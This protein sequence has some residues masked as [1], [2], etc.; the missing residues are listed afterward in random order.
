MRCHV[1]YSNTTGSIDCQF[2]ATPQFLSARLVE[3]DNKHWCHFHCPVK[4]DSGKG[5]DKS[6]WQAYNVR[7]LQSD[8]ASFIR[9]SA[10][11]GL[12]VNLSYVVF[13]DG[14]NM[15]GMAELFSNQGCSFIFDYSKFYCKIDLKKKELTNTNFNCAT[16][17]NFVSFIECSLTYSS[18]FN[19]TFDGGSSFVFCNFLAC[20]FD[21]VIFYKDA[22]FTEAMFANSIARDEE[23][24]F[25]DVV[26]HGKAIFVN[27]VFCAG[28]SLRNIKFHDLAD[29]SAQSHRI[30]DNRNLE[31]GVFHTISFNG[32]SFQEVDFTNRKFKS[33]TDFT[34]CVFNKAPNFHGCIFHQHTIFPSQNNFKDVSTDGAASAY[35]VIY[36]AM[37]DLKDRG[38]ES[39][40]YALVQRSERKSG[41]QPYHVRVAS[42]LYEVTT[43]Y[44]Q[45]IGRP[46]VVLLLVTI[47]FSCLYA[48]LASPVIDVY[49]SIDWGIVGNSIDLSVFQIVKPFAFYSDKSTKMVQIL[50]RGHP[51]TFKLTAI[52][53]TIFSLSLVTLFLLSLRWKF[54]KD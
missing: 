13:P 37:S 6:K 26:F 33:K 40:F 2:Q 30:Y 43:N 31:E 9:L 53:Q 44:G 14:F 4:N 35:R 41:M 21:N 54:K 24:T 20:I 3:F 15:N 38:Y 10:S 1:S 51:I 22:V 16:F 49:A 8:L 19:V 23:T 34:A 11:Q 32:C 46:L 29:F 50:L 7:Q 18:F 12:D 45:S 47:F 36:R 25:D 28:I 48:L 17:Y 39:M 52:C 5:S 42:W 27:A